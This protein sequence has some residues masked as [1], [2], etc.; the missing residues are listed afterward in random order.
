MPRKP[1]TLCAGTCGK[2]LFG[3]KSSLPAGQ[4][5]CHACRARKPAHAPASARTPA[6]LRFCEVCERQF[7]ASYSKQRT[8]GRSCGWAL[9]VREGNVPQKAEPKAKLLMVQEDHSCEI[10][11]RTWT[12]KPLEDGM[13]A[14][15]S[16]TCRRR[17]AGVREVGAIA[18]VTC[19]ACST[20]I[21]YVVRRGNRRHYCDPC[22]KAR[23]VA[24]KRRSKRDS[25]KDHRQRARRYGVSYEPISK[26]YILE[27]DKWMC[28]ICR[29]RI[30]KRHV[31]PHPMSPSL[32]HMVPMARGGGHVRANV[33]ASHW[34]CNATKS[35]GL[36]SAGEQLMLIG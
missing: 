1:D 14:I 3:G 19:G 32:D 7:K 35:D 13:R 31:Y 36:V 30:S 27:R 34:L 20:S 2:L 12:G 26:A 15:C 29:K 4:R 9:R 25:G 18:T 24:R 6:R 8:C 23:R 28:G 10:C 5:M 33:Q 22:A 21:T 11:G 16:P 17:A